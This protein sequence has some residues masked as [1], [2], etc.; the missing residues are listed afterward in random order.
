MAAMRRTFTVLAALAV[1]GGCGGGEMV[2]PP[3]FDAG[4]AG[5]SGTIPVGP[6]F[7]I[8]P[9]GSDS[10]G[11]GSQ[12]APWATPH[13][14]QA[15]IRSSGL[16][17]GMTA[18]ITVV[19]APGAYWFGEGAGTLA[20]TDADSP[21]NGWTVNYTTSDAPGS[22]AWYGGA[23][24]TGWQL[25]L[26]SIYRAAYWG[27]HVDTLWENGVR[28][29][30]ARYPAFVADASFSSSREPYNITAGVAGSV[31]VMQYTPGDLTPGAWD[32][33]SAQ[34]VVWPGGNG[35]AWFQETLPI[36]SINTAAHQITVQSPGAI[37]PFF[38]T[39]GARYFVQGDLSFLVGPGQ[40][41]HD[42]VNGWL[43]YWPN[44]MPIASQTIVAPTLNSI[45]T[46]K[47]SDTSHVASNFVFDGIELA[48]TKFPHTYHVG[49][50][51][52]VG[53][54]Y[55]V[56]ADACQV[57]R[58]NI[59]NTGTMGINLHSWAHGWRF[60][61]DWIHNTGT[62]AMVIENFPGA[63][64]LSPNIGD[65]NTGHLITNCRFN[66]P[67]E[68]SG[69]A[70]AVYVLNASNNTIEYSEFHDGP[71]IGV[72]IIGA[73]G[74]YGPSKTYAKGNLI[75]FT[76]FKSF[77][78]DSGDMGQIYIG[79]NGDNGSHPGRNT[80]QWVTVDHTGANATM[81]DMPPN[82]IFCDDN[83]YQQIFTNVSITNTLGGAADERNNVDS[84]HHTLS[85]VSWADGFVQ[86][87]TSNIGVK[88]DFP[89]EEGP[90]RRSVPGRRTPSLTDPEVRGIPSALGGGAGRWGTSD[91]TSPTGVDGSAAMAPPE[92]PDGDGTGSAQSDGSVP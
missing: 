1:A 23:R 59:H 69:G 12:V 28:A 66:N 16:L 30:N 50:T 92:S 77:G 76:K 83:S 71:R 63:P 78:G 64:P 73:F 5:R 90:P 58:C 7:Y 37:Y 82:G 75:Q 41:Y 26:G 87:D 38:E 70:Y 6:T 86:F 32:L 61:K 43:Y 39:K 84:G 3:T 36:A 48:Y 42:T 29:I 60:E 31:T 80:V 13:K 56:N 74:R 46:I 65:V 14:A 85:N 89:Y 88:G 9:L 53:A 2:D 15:F 55:A 79:Q 24:V 4:G 34:V 20:L 33:N 40:F 51:E 47:G 22:V 68:M 45:V 18:P 17:S 19:S 72:A 62:E 57:L 49:S 21:S 35:R 10:S 25:Y 67:G 44:N 27:P 11:D 8:S 52:L 91:R 54:I 81:G